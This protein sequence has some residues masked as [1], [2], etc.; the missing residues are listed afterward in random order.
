[1]GESPSP[2]GSDRTRP[3]STGVDVGRGPTAARDLLGLRAVERE[4]FGI[5]L[6][7]LSLR[8]LLLRVGPGL[9]VRHESPSLWVN[10]D[11]RPTAL[12]PRH[13]HK[14]KNASLRLHARVYLKMLTARAATSRIVIAEMPDSASIS[15]LAQRVSGIESVGLN[16]IELVNET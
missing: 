14:V 12:L 1:M 4:V 16:A 8:V 15:S 10:V 7:M 13:S 9:V 3:G 11:L 5:V 6:L 2:E